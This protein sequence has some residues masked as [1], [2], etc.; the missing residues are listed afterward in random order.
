MD[1]AIFE[2]LISVH[3]LRADGGMMTANGGIASGASCYR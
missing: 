3:R 2:Q 1:S